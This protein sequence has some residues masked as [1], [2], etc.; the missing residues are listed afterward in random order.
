[1]ALFA[2]PTSPVVTWNDS[3]LVAH[4][5]VAE[6]AVVGYPHALKG[7]GIYAYVILGAD[8][9]RQEPGQKPLLPERRLPKR[10]QKQLVPLPKLPI[11]VHELV[12]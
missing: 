12:I 8:W 9:A 4:P 10:E 7:Q 2:E 5:K 3:A 1:M 11:Q 6:S